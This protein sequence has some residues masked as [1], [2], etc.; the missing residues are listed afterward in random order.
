MESWI[1]KIPSLKLQLE[2]FDFTLAK[3]QHTYY[4][5]FDEEF[6]LIEAALAKLDYLEENEVLDIDM[7]NIEVSS[8]FSNVNISDNAEASLYN[9]LLERL[10]SKNPLI[11]AHLL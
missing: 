2:E 4:E 8:L 10:K 3:A 1:E 9:S 11:Q 7:Q 6:D 5:L